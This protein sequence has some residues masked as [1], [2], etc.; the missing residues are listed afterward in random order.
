MLRADLL[1]ELRYVIDDRVKPYY[2][3]D[4]R[5]VQWLSEGQDKF[6]EQTGFWTDR[7]SYSIT[8]VE[9]QTDYPIPS[10][11]IVEVLSV[12]D[13]WRRLEVF[14]DRDRPYHGEE[15]VTATP[16]APEF[17]QVD[18]ETGVISLYA[19][20]I[21]G[22][23]LTLRVKRLSKVSFATDDTELEIPE[24]FHLATVEYAASKAFGDH[25]RELQDPVK[26]ADHALNFKRY[27]V[28]G[29]RQWRRI[30]GEK[31]GVAPSLAYVF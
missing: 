14:R 17:Y 28:D 7:S 20:P 6:C 18:G 31:T 11:R 19:P 24:Q 8:T 4:A 3:T 16:N 12:W 25:D 9:G 23:V 13:G 5:L 30:S 15:F 26:A 10:D 29:E 22:V 2:W 27:R 1:T 21:A